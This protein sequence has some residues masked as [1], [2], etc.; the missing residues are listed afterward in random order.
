MIVTLIFITTLI[1]GIALSLAYH[2]ADWSPLWFDSAGLTCV[3][4]GTV[5]TI[6]SL[7]IILGNIAFVDIVYD[8]KL[9]ERQMLEYRIEHYENTVGNEL[10]YSDILKFNN[11]LRDTKRFANS[12]WLSWFNNWKIAELD[13]ISVEEIHQKGE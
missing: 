5:G 4:I 8:K 12:P 1:T 6:F 9:A 7:L 11:D 13:Y 2:R 3:I 10:L